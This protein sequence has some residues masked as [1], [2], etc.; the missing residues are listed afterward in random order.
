ML[1][2]HGVSYV[3]LWRLTDGLPD[4]VAHRR[5]SQ[6]WNRAGTVPGPDTT[7]PCLRGL[8]FCLRVPEGSLDGMDCGEGG[9]KSLGRQ[10]EIR[11]RYEE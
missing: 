9:V 7:D 1:L 10:L 5:A 2:T 3:S 8:W 11:G 6:D 4:L